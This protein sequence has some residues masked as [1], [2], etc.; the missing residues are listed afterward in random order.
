M[1][2]T[3][4][5]HNN[6]SKISIDNI[7]QEILFVPQWEK[8]KSFMISKNIFLFD[9][10]IVKVDLY[11]KFS[12]KHGIEKYALKYDDNK[13]I[14]SMDLKI[15]KDSVYIINLDIKT[16]TEEAIDK[17]LQAAVEKALY[18]T[19]EK[20]VFINLSQDISKKNR[21]RKILLNSQFETEQNQSEYEK[22]LFGETFKLKAENNQY[23]QKKIKQIPIL[24]NK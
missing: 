19:T 15:Y 7:A 11:R 2:N 1:I 8:I 21:I 13:I 9:K 4:L 5:K 10:S 16:I 17:L 24:I 6:K 12:S 3:I 23:W 18:N 22:K 20:E 14:A